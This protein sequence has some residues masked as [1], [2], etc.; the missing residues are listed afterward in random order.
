METKP[1]LLDTFQIV[2][3]ILSTLISVILVIA[4]QDTIQ[5]IALGL[6]LA[7]LTQLFDL[8]IRNAEAEN[9]IIQASALNKAIYSIRLLTKHTNSA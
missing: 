5:S 2:G 4:N 9:R 8:Q 7:T 3:F 6:I 1:K